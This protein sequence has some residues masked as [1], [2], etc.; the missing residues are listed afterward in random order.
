MKKYLVD[1][2]SWSSSFGL[3]REII[4]FKKCKNSYK[5]SYKSDGPW[6]PSFRLWPYSSDEYVLF[7][8]ANDGNEARE[9]ADK[10]RFDKQVAHMD[11][12]YNKFINNIN[13]I[14]PTNIAFI[15]VG[16]N[17]LIVFS[18]NNSYTESDKIKFTYYG[19]YLHGKSENEEG[20]KLFNNYIKKAIKEITHK[21]K[22]IKIIDPESIYSEDA[23]SYF[24]INKESWSY[25]IEP[26][27]KVLICN[28]INNDGIIKIYNLDSAILNE[29][30]GSKNFSI[31]DVI[32]KQGDIDIIGLKFHM[33]RTLNTVQETNILCKNH[34]S[35]Y[36][37]PLN[38]S[39]INAV[40]SFLKRK[41]LVEISFGTD[42][43]LVTKNDV[44]NIFKIYD[45][46]DIILISNDVGEVYTERYRGRRGFFCKQLR[47]QLSKNEVDSWE[48]LYELEK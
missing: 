46:S 23:T 1:L 6:D 29:I 33:G 24:F 22:L 9:I 28:D 7:V 14:D 5:F 8:D 11:I 12:E 48:L 10:I 3:P 31:R 42:V 2:S 27:R 37:I 16:Y 40:H 45:V 17:E 25:S 13:S 19:K 30:V 15:E 36:D 47:N 38:I 44:L 41:D 32:T 35:R 26:G 18:K 20:I 4:N 39:N 21:C 34:I 43:Y